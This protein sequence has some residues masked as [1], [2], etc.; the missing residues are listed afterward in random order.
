MKL[1]LHLTWQRGELSGASD[2]HRTGEAWARRGSWLGI[3]GVTRTHETH[4]IV[5]G[6]RS[7]K[8]IVGHDSH[9]RTAQRASRDGRSGFVATNFMAIA[10]RSPENHRLIEPRLWLIR[11]EIMA[12]DFFSLVG[13]NFREIV[14]TNRLPTGSNGH[15]FWV[16]IS[17]KN[18]C[19]PFLVF[20]F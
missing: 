18:R 6:R 13:H 17:F 8:E 3:V 1:D 4:W 16:E 11:G 20:N 14:A 12:H 2:L 19:I 5:I 10:A 15:N 7:R 9:D